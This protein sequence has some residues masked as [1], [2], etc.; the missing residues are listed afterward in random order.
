MNERTSGR[1]V[2]RLEEFGVFRAKSLLLR[3][4]RLG[5]ERRGFAAG[6][7]LVFEVHALPQQLFHH[8]HVGVFGILLL[9]VGSA[10]H[11]HVEFETRRI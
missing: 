4:R 2:P 7:P 1:C 6:A 11:A 9:V 8:H 3:R 10:A 5:G